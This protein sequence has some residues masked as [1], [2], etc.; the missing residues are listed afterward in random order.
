VAA[1][2]LASARLPDLQ[3]FE[4]GAEEPSV[5]TQENISL[6]LSVST[7]QEICDNAEPGSLPRRVM[8]TPQRASQPGGLARERR[9]REAEV[10]HGILKFR[11]ILKVSTDLCPDDVTGNQCS[12]VKRCAQRFA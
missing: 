6:D 5:A 9:K 1:L 7:D 10:P 4:I 11:F 8:P 12:T 3:S 2:T